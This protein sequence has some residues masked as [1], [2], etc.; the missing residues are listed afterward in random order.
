[1]IKD[2]GRRWS[3]GVLDAGQRGTKQFGVTLWGNGVRVGFQVNA[4]RWEL[5]IMKEKR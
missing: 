4:W 1:M 3:V 5:Q 2:F